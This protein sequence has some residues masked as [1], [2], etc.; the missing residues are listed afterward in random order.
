MWNIWQSLPGNWWRY[1]VWAMKGLIQGPNTLY[2]C[3]YKNLQNLCFTARPRVNITV[4]FY[5]W[6]ETG[7][8]SF[9]ELKETVILICWH[10]HNSWWVWI[11]LWCKLRQCPQ[12]F[13]SLLWLPVT[14]GVELLSWGYLHWRALYLQTVS[15][16]QL[17][18]TCTCWM[19]WRSLFQ[20]KRCLYG[21]LASSKDSIPILLWGLLWVGGRVVFVLFQETRF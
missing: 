10:S 9:R 1:N 11:G 12:Q 7:F 6:V 19:I 18:T 15:P 21:R 2:A 16:D 13:V 20:M 3:T 17:L 8:A 5:A 14:E 4:F